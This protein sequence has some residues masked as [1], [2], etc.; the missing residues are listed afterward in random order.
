MLAV[1][2]PNKR[3][4]GDTSIMTYRGHSVS[5]TL[6][7]CHF[8]PAESTGQRYIYTGCAT[9]QVVG[10]VSRSSLW[11][12]AKINQIACI[13]IFQL[14]FTNIFPVYDVLTGRI[15]KQLKGHKDCVRDVSWHPHRPEIISVSVST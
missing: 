14:F 5:Q 9:G 6:F 4:E 15:E 12:V 13:T 8:S 11:L 2:N 1:K 10:T 7:R 3:L